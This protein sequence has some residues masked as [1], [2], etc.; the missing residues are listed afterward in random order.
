MSEE[1]KRNIAR[2]NV[3]AGMGAS[4]V[5][6]ALG[7]YGVTAGEQHDNH[8]EYDVPVAVDWQESFGKKGKWWDLEAFPDENNN[9]IQDSDIDYC[10]EDG[11]VNIG[12][13]LSSGLRTDDDYTDPGDP[14]INF[15]GIKPG[16][17]GEVTLSYHLC[18]HPGKVKLKASDVKVNKKL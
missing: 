15:H 8:D 13:P 16:Y 12:D 9:R 2:R 18:D 6:L 17:R 10:G 5:G 11:L 1:T 4:G 14:L 7:A 3:L